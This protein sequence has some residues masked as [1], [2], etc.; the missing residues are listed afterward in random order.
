M[1]FLIVISN[2]YVS[3]L[4]DTKINLTMFVFFS[5]YTIS[6][7]IRVNYVNSTQRDKRRHFSVCPLLFGLS[8][9]HILYIIDLTRFHNFSS[10]ELLYL[11]SVINF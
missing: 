4:K 11:Y 2:Y 10:S 8:I 9:I 1:V 7:P 6:L 5:I 3:Y